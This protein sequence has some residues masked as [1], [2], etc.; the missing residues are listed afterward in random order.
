MKKAMG[1]FVALILALGMSGL[2]YATW[3]ETLIISGTVNTGTVDVSW[4][5]VGSWD[6]D[7]YPYAPEGKDVS[8]IRCWIDLKDPNLLHVEV[9]NAYPSIDY[10]NVVD[11]HCDGSIPVHLYEV[12]V[13]PTDPA[14]QV[15][16]SYWEDPDATIPAFLPVQLHYCDTIYVLIH[17]HITQDALQNH[18]YTFDAQ[19][20]AVQW[21][22]PPHI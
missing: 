11:I 7:D 16:I 12:F 20:Q 6:T 13:S 21:N 18:I 22:M 3:M 19:I 4:S 2:A 15:D 5:E 8:G 1:M 17:V 10:Y 14:V 9:T